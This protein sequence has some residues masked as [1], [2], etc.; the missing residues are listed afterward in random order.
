MSG[1]IAAT[2]RPPEPPEPSLPPPAALR[3]HALAACKDPRAGSPNLRALWRA[4]VEGRF[5][6]V[7]CFEQNGCRYFVLHENLDAGADAGLTPREL[8]LVEEVGR[9]G[10]EKCVAFALGVTP[11]VASA[12]LKSALLKLGLRS[13]VDLVVLVGAMRQSRACR[14]GASPRVQNEQAAGS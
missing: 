5:R 7:E 4:L 11:S 13:K 8:R 9:G 10:S 6:F 2:A 12:L 1:A 14:P 3:E